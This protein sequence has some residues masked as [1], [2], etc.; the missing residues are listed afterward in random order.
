MTTRWAKPVYIRSMGAFLP[1][2]PVPNSQITQHIGA[3]HSKHSALLLKKTLALNGIKNRHYAMVNEKPTHLNIDL[4]AGA[5][6]DALQNSHGISVN[7]VG[8]LAAGTSHPDVILPGFAN[9]V[10]GRIGSKRSMDCLSSGGVCISSANALKAAAHAVSLGEH[11]R[12]LVVGSEA[13]SHMLCAKRYKDFETM[14]DEGK[15]DLRSVFDI[16][17][18]RYML[19]DGAGCALLD[20]E[21][22]PSKL[23][24][25]IEQFYHHSFAHELPP[26][27][28][29]GV[30]KA[31]KP[32]ELEEIYKVNETERLVG[33]QD[34]DLLNKEIIVRS[35]ESLEAALEQGFLGDG[36]KVDWV[37]PH[38]SSY[39]FYERSALVLQEVLGIRKDRIWTN[40]ATVGNA[41]SASMMLLLW[42]LLNDE[43]RP[44]I[45]KGDRVLLCIP[46]SGNFSYH[47]VSL[48]VVDSNG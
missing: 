6:R 14:L 24:F 7:Q 21:P 45:K 25:R 35:K 32:I 3:I 30:P 40:L 47:Y 43:N 9:L 5:V 22:H 48:E 41:G 38:I 4:A 31:G 8:M 42:G 10:H 16:E 37:L 46:E 36:K 19:S 33:H 44:I 13:A 17:F 39:F 26:C 15:M 29:L 2:D 27:M 34:T 12:A 11:S 28:V 1:N 23:S 18:V 20:H